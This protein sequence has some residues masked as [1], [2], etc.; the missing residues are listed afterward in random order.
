MWTRSFARLVVLGVVVLGACEATATPATSTA[1]S[2]AESER[3]DSP[4]PRALLDELQTAGPL[5]RV[6]TITLAGNERAHVAADACTEVLVRIEE[7][8]F[9]GHVADTT[10]IARAPFELRATEPTRLFVAA[11]RPEDAP[12]GAPCSRE[13]SSALR[14]L[15]APEV[16]PF[17]GGKLRVRIF[18]DASS[19]ARFGALS[20]LDGDADLPVPPHVHEAS[21]EALLVREGD[22]TMLQGDAESA[23]APGRVLYVPPNVRHGYTPGTTKLVAYQIYAP[24][25]PEQR[26]RTPPTP[27]AFA[28]RD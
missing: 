16:L 11:V 21:V 23:I 5:V 14:W 10:A 3:R 12:F 8:A 13:D 20:M 17:A 24:G 2:S 6:G 19:G 25:G 15:P 28:P 26:F 1:A 4:P 9:D 18:A 22:G 7:G 27:P